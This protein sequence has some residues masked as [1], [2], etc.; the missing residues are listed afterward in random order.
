MQALRLLGK[1][2]GV[3]SWIGGVEVDVGQLSLIP[4]T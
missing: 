1:L 2:L 4:P 3:G